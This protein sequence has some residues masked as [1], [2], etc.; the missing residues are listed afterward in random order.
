MLLSSVIYKASHR[1]DSECVHLY[2][3]SLGIAFFDSHSLSVIGVCCV[4]D[5]LSYIR[6][7]LFFSF[8]FFSEYFICAIL[9]FRIVSPSY[10]SG[11]I[12][13]YSHFSYLYLYVLIFIRV[14]SDFILLSS[15]F[16]FSFLLSEDTTQILLNSI[17]CQHNSSN[18]LYLP[19]VILC[20]FI[21]QSLLFDNFYLLYRAVINH[22]LNSSLNKSHT[23]YV[24]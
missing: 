12:I 18:S 15:L 23:C 8:I 11:I 20:S 16:L 14:A 21:D 5:F 3:K 9:A 2:T 7:F 10:I 22:V 1:S 17:S 24:V 19:I 4:F 6:V 13:A